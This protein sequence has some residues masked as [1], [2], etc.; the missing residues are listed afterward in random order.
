MHYM[1]NI[2]NTTLSP[3][4]TT[5]LSPYTTTT[6]APRSYRFDQET[7]DIITREAGRMGVSA[8]DVIR[9]AVRKLAKE[10]AGSVKAALPASSPSS[11]P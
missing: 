10:A 5:T 8:A 1:P 11:T 4:T 6:L 2:T 7:L 9:I 3:Y